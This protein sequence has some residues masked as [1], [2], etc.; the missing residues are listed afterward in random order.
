MTQHIL[1]PT[2]DHYG[3]WMLYAMDV[4]RRAIAESDRKYLSPIPD[5][6]V[7][8]GRWKKPLDW[9]WIFLRY[10]RHPVRTGNV[11]GGM[12]DAEW[13]F[14]VIVEHRRDDLD[15]AEQEAILILGDIM[16]VIVVDLEMALLY[17]GVREVRDIH[18]EFLE[19][20]LV[21]GPTEQDRSIW[22]GLR[23]L[24]SKKLSLT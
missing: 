7:H 18:M 6:R 14:D 12:V 20:A 17:E 1:R 19:P 22:I 11:S 15:E 8:I 2:T 3:E 5:S 23:L 16:E 21:I 13:T 9:P 10:A 4:L 24:V